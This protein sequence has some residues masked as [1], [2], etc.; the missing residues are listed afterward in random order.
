[1]IQWTIVLLLAALVS[2]IPGFDWIGRT[3]LAAIGIAFVAWFAMFI[4]FLGVLFG[5]RAV[6]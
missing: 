5:R 1:M 2:F 3:L 4:L 6:A